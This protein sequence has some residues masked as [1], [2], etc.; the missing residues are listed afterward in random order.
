MGSD[1]SQADCW[2]RGN[3]KGKYFGGQ[4]TCPSH[5]PPSPGL[6]GFPNLQTTLTDSFS[7][8]DTG[9][10][11]SVVWLKGPDFVSM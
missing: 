4:R 3:V 10:A 1:Q 7:S 8:R 6:P 2:R 11:P 5:G 9:S